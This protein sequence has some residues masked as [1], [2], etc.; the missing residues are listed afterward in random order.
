[1]SISH[2]L[3][4]HAAFDHHSTNSR[5][6]RQTT[7]DEFSSDDSSPSTTRVTCP[8]LIF[9]GFINRSTINNTYFQTLADRLL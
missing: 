6:T 9:V 3:S 1:M 4:H 7:R 2:I 8:Y 5:E